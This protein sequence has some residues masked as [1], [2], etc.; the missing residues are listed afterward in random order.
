[1]LTRSSGRRAVRMALA[2]ILVPVSAQAADEGR[3]DAG[4]RV[5]LTAAS[6]VPAN[7]I[8]GAGVYGRYRLGDRWSVGLSF[9]QAKFDYEEPARRL[10][11]PLDP[12]APPI[13]AKADM[14]IVSVLAERRF[15]AADSRREWILGAQLGLAFTDV[16]DVTGPTAAGGTFDI[17]TEV[18]RELILSLQGGVRQRLTERWYAEFV[19]RADQHFAA[20]EPEDRISGATG[21]HDDYFAYGFHLGVGYRF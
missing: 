14:Q 11:I 15:P 5:I 12:D 4:L 20:W 17:F 10:G 6:G 2:A 16:P 13:D 19:L 9:E 3:V 21:R 1:M 18:D 7:D 8:P